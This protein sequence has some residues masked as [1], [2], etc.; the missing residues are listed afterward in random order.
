MKAAQAIM[1][2]YADPKDML[3]L[4]PL[5]FHLLLSLLDGD[6]H[7][8]GMNKAI[9]MR[10]EGEISLEAGSLYHTLQRMVTGGL[11]RGPEEPSGEDGRR[12]RNYRMTE[13]GHRVL[14]AEEQ[15][16]KKML[17][18]LVAAKKSESGNGGGA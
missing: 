5:V 17:G 15:R 4:S 6:L 18:Y 12:R 14:E 2:Q 3:P 16:L 1:K 10:T 7:G 11:I 9:E 8:Y 13:F